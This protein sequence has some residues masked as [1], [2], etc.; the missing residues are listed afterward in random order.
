MRATSTSTT[1]W[2]EM[3]G[4]LSTSLSQN[5]A[6]RP[7]MSEFYMMLGGYFINSLKYGRICCKASTFLWTGKNQLDVM[8]DVMGMWKN[9]GL[10]YLT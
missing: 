4:Y 7:S 2:A 5:V 9:C 3:G 10:F 1:E 8:A 6:L